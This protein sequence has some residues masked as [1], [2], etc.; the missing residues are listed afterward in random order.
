MSPTPGCGHSAGAPWCSAES[1]PPGVCLLNP[2]LSFPL[3]PR[4]CDST[5]LARGLWG[6]PAFGEEWMPDRETAPRWSHCRAPAPWLQLQ[7]ELIKAE[8]AWG[9][10]W[11]HQGGG[12]GWGSPRG[13]PRRPSGSAPAPLRPPR[14]PGRGQWPLLCTAGRGATGP[15][16]SADGALRLPGLPG[17]P[18]HPRKEG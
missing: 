11:D 1:L 18:A 16:C 15:S 13:G 14:R 4:S 8:G 10:L 6:S 3:A 17:G 2:C 5:L 12:A 7:K 9:W